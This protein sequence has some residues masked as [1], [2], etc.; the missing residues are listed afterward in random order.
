MKPCRLVL[1]AVSL[2]LAISCASS[3]SKKAALPPP[4]NESQKQLQ[5]L[6]QESWQR[7][8]IENQFLRL[9]LGLAV[10]RLPD[11][12]FEKAA[13]EAEFANSVHQ[14]AE[15]IDRTALSEDERTTLD[16]LLYQTAMTSEG[17]QH[18]WMSSPVTPYG[19]MITK[20]R[21]FFTGYRFKSVA[22]L[23]GYTHLLRKHGRLLGQ[24]LAHLRTQAEMG[25][26]LPADAIDGVLPLIAGLAQP[27]ASSD[28]MVSPERL[29]AIPEGD[30]ESFQKEVTA[31]I[32]ED[33][34]PRFGAIS[35]LLT[36]LRS[37]RA[38][39]AVGLW[40]YPGG[41]AYY[42]Y[43]V[44]LHTTLEITP[45]QVHQAGLTEVARLEKA[46]DRLQASL[47]SPASRR[48]FLRS[49]REDQRFRA[50][51]AEQIGER[52]QEY[53]ARIE[54]LVPKLFRRTPEAA[55]GV[56]RL[57]PA[58]EGSMT[59][60]YYQ[61]PTASDPRGTYYYN[62][63][64]PSERPLLQ[65]QSVIYHEL[66]PGHHFQIA[67]QLENK[68]LPALRRFSTPT[69]FVEGWAEYA[70]GLGQELKLYDDPYLEYGR[71]CAEMFLAVRLVVDTGMNH[72]RW[73]R[74]QAIEYMQDHVLESKTQIAT[75]T[76]RYSTDIQ[77][78]ALAYKM[79][80]LKIWELRRH[81]EAELGPA[82]DVRAFHELV[83]DGGALP[84]TLLEDRVD[85]FIEQRQSPRPVAR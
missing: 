8:R 58:L 42:A 49:L 47:G 24:V 55:Y 61:Q 52:M 85:A 35:E 84:L 34:N 69:A 56:A 80:A 20:L 7:E 12:S 82:F 21:R 74:Q 44:R 16:L 22:D 50:R 29:K 38:P 76:L 32:D 41:D 18:F 64:R 37:H 36:N 14:R 27:S 81:A 6:L 54:P 30:R 23:E 11:I 17:I 45:E 79:G 13:E 1:A 59:Y 43:L 46:M 75:E 19:S 72:L 62:G 25:I 2:A 57:D 71:Y 66:I 70:S 26:I 83:L 65:L 73:T 77:G 60:G 40:Q 31:L 39:R 10:R 4:V 33:I 68:S 63:L 28:L 3:G 48:E 78:Q 51:K 5:L 9:D 15:A 67:R 53:L